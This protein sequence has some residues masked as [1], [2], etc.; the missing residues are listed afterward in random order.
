MSASDGLDALRGGSA[1]NRGVKNAARERERERER[2]RALIGTTV[3]NGG[4]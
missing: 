4:V 1:K 2:E 3:Y